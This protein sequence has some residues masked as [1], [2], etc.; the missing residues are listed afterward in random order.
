MDEGDG[1]LIEIHID[2]SQLDRILRE[3]LASLPQA[4][5]TILR[6][7]GLEVHAEA[8]RQAPVDRGELRAGITIE[9]K[10]GEVVIAA[11]AKHS[12]FAETGTRPHTPPFAPIERWALRHGIPPGAVWSSIRKRGTRAKPF[13]APAAAHGDRIFAAIAQEEI[14]RWSAEGT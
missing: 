7:V 9:E 1:R 10:E 4:R 3:R 5:R 6:R 2:S 11:T 8:N 12:A 13:M 14:D